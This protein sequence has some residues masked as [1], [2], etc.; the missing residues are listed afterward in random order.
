MR[1]RYILREGK[2]VEITELPA[3][4]FMILPDLPA[5]QSPIDGRVID[6]RRAR[7]NDLARSGCRPYEGREQEALEAERVKAYSEAAIDRLLDESVRSA[8]LG[9]NARKR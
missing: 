5:Y 7:R 3:H 9:E 1:R 8:Y 6:G 4:V 2:L